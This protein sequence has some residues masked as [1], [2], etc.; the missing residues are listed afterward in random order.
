MK[1]LVDLSY[2]DKDNPTGVSVF[3]LRLLHAIQKLVKDIDFVFLANK[4]SCEYIKGKFPNSRVCGGLDLPK[5]S[6]PVNF[7]RKA[8]NEDK[9]EKLISVESVDLFFIPFLYYRFSCF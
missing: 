5:G 9:I 6:N 3:A 7:I 4:T 2:V 8:Y 1:I